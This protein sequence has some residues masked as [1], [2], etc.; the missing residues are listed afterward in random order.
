L[1]NTS[2]VNLLGSVN[3]SNAEKLF[4]LLTLTS[5]LGKVAALIA[6]DE[7]WMLSML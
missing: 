1:K 4:S 3:A 2:Q 5:N 6:L 7:K